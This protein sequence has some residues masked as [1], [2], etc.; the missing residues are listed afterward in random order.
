MIKKIS[1][2]IFLLMFSTSLYAQETGEKKLKFV[3]PLDMVKWTVLDDFSTLDKWDL[4]AAPEK[5]EDMKSGKAYYKK[6][7]PGVVF[8]HVVGE[9]FTDKYQKDKYGKNPSCLGVKILFPEFSKEH[10]FI[11]PKESWKIDGVCKLIWVWLLGRGNNVDLEIILRDY[12]GRTYFLPVANLDFLGWKYSKI[13]V[14]YYIP[15]SFN[16]H[17]QRKT[18]EILGFFAANNPAQYADR[19]HEPIYIYIDQFEVM[20][21]RFADYYPGLE[22]QDEW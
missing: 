2:F 16:V 13:K 18:I 4:S 20:V 14:P 5:N 22:I 19:V 1:C 10:V 11:G 7:E 12:L 15:Q 3:T 21:D 17:P 9:R 8:Q 6:T